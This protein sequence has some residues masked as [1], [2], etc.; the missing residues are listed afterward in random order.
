[1][2]FCWCF[3]I[4][5]RKDVRCRPLRSCGRSSRCCWPGCGNRGP[6]ETEGPG[7]EMGAWGGKAP[8]S[9]NVFVRRTARGDVV[10]PSVMAGPTSRPAGVCR[11]G[12]WGPSDPISR[13]GG[14]RELRPR[15]RA[16]R[17]RFGDTHWAISGPF[18]RPQT[19]FPV[20]PMLAR[21]PRF[22]PGWSGAGF[23][24]SKP[25]SPQPAGRK[26]SQETWATTVFNAGRHWTGESGRCRGKQ[27]APR[28]VAS[29]PAG[30]AQEVRSRR[31]IFHGSGVS[32]R[33]SQET[34]G[35]ET[36]LVGPSSNLG[37]NS[38]MRH[39]PSHQGPPTP[40]RSWG[41]FER[42][43]PVSGNGPWFSDQHVVCRALQV[44]VQELGTPQVEVETVSGIDSRNPSF[45]Q[46]VGDVTGAGLAP[47]P[48]FRNGRGPRGR[49]PGGFPPRRVR[50]QFQ[51]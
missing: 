33:L 42:P 7:L 2:V 51:G 20:R 12:Y 46:A 35:R 36:M 23:G 27:V 50:L 24:R 17:G 18:P 45:L 11:G 48:D 26:L 49:P 14:P 38:S 5:G 13:V 25:C 29:G 40:L 1:M 16:R 9:G 34:R 8:G 3:G 6:S 37:Q 21:G 15:Q 10:R 4:G 44:A 32:A 22:S 47:G 28:G 41:A 31:K 39:C 19:A 30:P 43:P